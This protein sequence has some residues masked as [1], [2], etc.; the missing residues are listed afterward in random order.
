MKHGI[1]AEKIFL[2]RGHKVMIDRDLAQL[3]GVETKYLNRQVKRNRGRFPAEFMFQISKE[4]KKE[5]VTNCHRFKSMKHS[6]AL[7]YA[8][9]EH[10]GPS[11][12]KQAYQT[13][14]IVA[15]VVW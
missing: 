10:G 15:I 7:P 4:E 14:M 13:S 3:Y 5:L 2:M 6:S 9:T 1:I 12:L 11:F 8:F